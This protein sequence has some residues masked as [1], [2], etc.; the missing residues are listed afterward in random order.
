[1]S[2]TYPPEDVSAIVPPAEQPAP[3]E[4]PAAPPAQPPAG[5]P[6]VRWGFFALGF[7]TPSAVYML[8]ASIVSTINDATDTAA[9]LPG[10]L[11]AVVLSLATLGVAVGM[12]AAFVV[13]NRRENPRLRSFGLGGLI[14]YAVTMLISLLAFGA[15]LLTLGGTGLLGN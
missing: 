6:K 1:M 13:G 3:A 15:C 5:K 10:S 12:I 14:S 11:V 8:V 9:G 2:E 4:P 7:I